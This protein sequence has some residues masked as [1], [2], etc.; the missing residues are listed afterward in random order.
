ML[1]KQAL[2]VTRLAEV[3]GRSG[4]IIADTF[5]RDG[6]LKIDEATGELV[7]KTGDARVVVGEFADGVLKLIPHLVI[8]V[9]QPL[10]LK[11]K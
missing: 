3:S 2:A 4:S 9:C 6:L 8:K 7:V 5:V 11:E 1:E 10:M